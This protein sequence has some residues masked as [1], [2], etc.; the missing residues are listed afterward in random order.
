M[1]SVLN[2]VIAEYDAEGRFLRRVLQPVSGERLPFPSTGT[3]LGV[4]VDSLG[5]VYYADLGLVQN[6]LN[7][8]P[9]DNLGTVRRIVFDPNGNPLA[10][11][12]LDRNLDFPDGIGVWEPAR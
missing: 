1:T 12:T 2:G 8:G 10:P 7:I 3:P 6:G 9:G 5:S 4:A 11:V